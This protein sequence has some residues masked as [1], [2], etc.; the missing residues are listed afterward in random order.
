[1]IKTE[2]YYDF[3]EYYK[4]AD[5]LE[6]N[7]ISPIPGF[8]VNDP[9]MDNITIYDTTHRRQAGFSKV[10]EDI[11]GKRLRKDLVKLPDYSDKLEVFDFHYLHLLH[12]FTGSGASFEPT[13]LPTGFRNHKEHGYHNNIV[14]KVASLMADKADSELRNVELNHLN[15][16]N[17]AKAF[18][19]LNTAPMVTSIG[20]QPPS[21]KNPKPNEY[22]LAQQYYFNEVAADFIDAYL[23]FLSTN[24]YSSKLP[25]GI[26]EAVDFCLDWHKS[27]GFKQWHFVMT[28]FVMDTAEYYSRLVDKTSH[29][30]YGSNCIKTFDLMFTKEKTDP[31]S[32]AE[33]HE[34]CM[35]VLCESVNGNPYDVEDVCCDSIRYWKEYV[36]KG[37]ESLLPEQTKNSSIL[38]VN[39]IYPSKIQERIDFV[40]G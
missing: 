25:T 5:L 39:G 32:K 23:G 6:K 35:S 40:L 28:A 19:K 30:Y 9:I 16:L 3:I 27:R 15:K 24:L 36:P 34:L 17:I 10:L 20:N 18:I 7:N 4:K 31:K 26:K 37:Y 13:Y 14:G 1:M 12:R 2:F 21:L 8:V 38:K 11:H 33:F 22:R 29:C